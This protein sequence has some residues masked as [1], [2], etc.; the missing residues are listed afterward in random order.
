MA[1]TPQ[2]LI[3]INANIITLDSFSPQASWVV[4]EDDKIV[5]IG[6]GDEWKTLKYKNTEL[7]DCSGKTVLPGF[8]DAHLHLVSYARSFI[9]LD[10][11]P[12]EN[13]FSITDIQSII[14]DYSSKNPSSKWIFG[15]GYNEFYLAEKR[16]PNRWDLDK[17]AP[18]NPV[19]LM[20]RSRHAHVL[21]SLALK[22]VHISNE[23]GDPT[24]GLI[25]RDIKT[26]KPTGLLYE[27]GE[28]LSERIPP[29]NSQELLSYYALF[30]IGLE[31]RLGKSQ[32][33]HKDVFVIITQQRST[34]PSRHAITSHFNR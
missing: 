6:F 31:F 11:R 24:G 30:N 14:R 33:I 34:F 23:T 17:A 25:D 22:L 16:H 20:H 13:V 2:N 27:M 12:S 21:N 26:G 18:D 19:M 28:F 32:Q 15:G 10:L 3:L 8:I 9:T 7:I 4:T 5:S 1:K 29:L